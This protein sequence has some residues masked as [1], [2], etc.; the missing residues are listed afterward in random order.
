MAIIDP[1]L[2]R[3]NY[4]PLLGELWLVWRTAMQLHNLGSPSNDG[5]MYNLFYN[6]MKNKVAM[7]YIN[8][9]VENPQDQV[10]LVEFARLVHTLNI[11]RN[12]Q[13]M[14]GNNANLDEMDLY[15]ECWKKEIE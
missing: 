4:S 12:S 2:K 14:F 1:I 10:A 3:G 13:C 11:V 7:T 6:D 15:E 8:H 5:P 9:I